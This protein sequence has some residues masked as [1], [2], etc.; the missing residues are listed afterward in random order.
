MRP[1]STKTEELQLIGKLSNIHSKK[2][3][4]LPHLEMLILNTFGFWKSERVKIDLSRCLIV[5]VNAL[6]D[7]STCLDALATDG[8]VRDPKQSLSHPLGMVVPMGGTTIP[9]GWDVVS[10]IF[11]CLACMCHRETTTLV[12]YTTFTVAYTT[13]LAH[14]QL[15]T[16]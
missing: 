6:M 13:F 1:Y 16:S 2:N 15:V 10:S 9:N 3:W 11:F 5:L 14:Y 12:A 8:I 4:Q 7:R